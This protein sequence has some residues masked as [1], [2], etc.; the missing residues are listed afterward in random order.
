MSDGSVIT[1]TPESLPAPAKRLQQIDG[2]RGVAMLFVFFGHFSCMWLQYPHAQGAVDTFLRVVE[3][4]ATIGSSFFMLLSAFFTYGSQMRAKRGFADFLHGRLCRIYPLYLVVMA[5]YVV[6]SFAFPKLS[7][8]P[9][10]PADAAVFLLQTLLFLPGLI[11]VRPLMDVAWTLSFVMFFYFVAGILTRVFRRIA[12]PRRQ[13]FACLVVLALGW[14]FVSSITGRYEPRTATFWVGMALWEVVDAMSGERLKWAI[15]MTA[16]A[17][18]ITIAGVALRT[19]LMV[20]AST[21][22]LPHLMVWRFLITAVTLSAFVWIA[23]FGPAWWK[24]LL[25]GP[26]LA[27]LGAASYSFYL[28]HGFAIKA[29]RFGMI[30]LAGEAVSTQSFFWAS[31]FVGIGLAILIARISYVRVEQ[32]LAIWLASVEWIR[33]RPVAAP[34]RDFEGRPLASSS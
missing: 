18:V 27:M 14:A 16:P 8:L 17:V 33:P 28:T 25:S 12:L 5:V 13:R 30:P 20:N 26:R 1:Q 34:V 4:D 3:A 9:A 10:D 11:P 32:P 7:R 19:W 15:R 22:G 24:S 29:V 21:L 2:L 23:F 31:Q 6:G